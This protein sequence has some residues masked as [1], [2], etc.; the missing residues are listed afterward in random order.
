MYL[1]PNS[2]SLKKE[3]GGRKMENSEVWSSKECDM[4]F[5]ILHVFLEQVLLISY[6]KTEY[7]LLRFKRIPIIISSILSC[8]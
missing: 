5:S 2:I 8:S 1:N 3:K 4:I 6:L 7:D